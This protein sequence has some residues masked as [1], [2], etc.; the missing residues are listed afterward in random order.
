MPTVTCS[1][2]NRCRTRIEDIAN[3]RSTEP[4]LIS[5]PRLNPA[6]TG[7]VGQVRNHAHEKEMDEIQ[8]VCELAQAGTD[9][10]FIT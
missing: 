4:I 8:H 1:G 7:N 3:L 5:Q 10:F 9:K 6:K 2:A